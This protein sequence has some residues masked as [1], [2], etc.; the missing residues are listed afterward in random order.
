MCAL[1][2]IRSGNDKLFIYVK[3]V[4]VRLWSVLNLSVYHQMC[5]DLIF[6]KVYCV[7]STTT[8]YVPFSRQCLNQKLHCSCIH[9]CVLQ[10]CSSG[11]PDG[12]HEGAGLRWSLALESTG[13]PT[14]TG[15]IPQVH[16][17][18]S[19]QQH[20]QDTLKTERSVTHSDQLT[21]KHLITKC[22]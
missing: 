8:F 12:R 21:D 19:P 3:R 16:I 15:H 22:K 11:G 18:T 7:T 10:S 13:A 20:V 1:L 9:V 6:Y 2:E 4:V 14:S 17:N 5:V